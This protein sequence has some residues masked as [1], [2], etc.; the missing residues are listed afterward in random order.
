MPGVDVQGHA[1]LFAK[2]PED[3]LFFSGSWIFAQCSN[4]AEGI[5]ADE[6]IGVEFDDGGGD[7]IEKFLNVN[8]VQ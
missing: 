7:H 2:M 8:I 5:A 4:T 3:G 1:V 6:M